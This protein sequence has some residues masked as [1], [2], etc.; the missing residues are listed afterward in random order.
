LGGWRARKDRQPG[1]IVLTR[2]LRR[3][4]DMLATQAFLNCY[5]AHHGPLPPGIANLIQDMAQ[6]A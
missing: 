4:A 1:K 6:D 2:G 3:L 5:Q